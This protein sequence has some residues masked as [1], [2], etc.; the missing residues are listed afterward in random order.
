[1][2]KFVFYY[3]FLISS[4]VPLKMV[5]TRLEQPIIYALP[6]LS[7]IS[8]LLILTQSHCCSDRQ[9]P[10]LVLSR[11]TADRCLSLRLS[12]PGNRCDVLAFV[13]VGIVSRSS[14]L[15]GLLR[16]KP[17]K[18]IALP[19]CLSARSFPLTP[20]CPC[21][22]PLQVIVITIPVVHTSLL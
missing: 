22:L 19:T 2:L 10:C 13:P 1:M 3:S 17:L 9:W 18:L 5:S 4:S 7:D 20:A 8:L 12:P 21:L 6:H 14:T 15:S 11:Q 16:R